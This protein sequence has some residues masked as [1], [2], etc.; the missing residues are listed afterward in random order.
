MKKQEEKPEN[1][2]RWLLTYSDL[3]TLLMIFF[4]V[5]YAGS[6]A[7]ATKYK[8]LS[9][10]FKV[11]LG[12]GKTIVGKEEGVEI[13]QPSKPIETDIKKEEGEAVKTEENK[14]QEVKSN[15]DKY[16]E[17]SS[18]KGSVSTSIEERGLVISLKDTLVFDSGKADIKPECKKQL[19]ELGAILN[20]IDNYI[21]V[22]GH[23]DNVPINTNN[24][25][26]NWQLSVIRATNVT[27]LLIKDSNIVSKRLSAVGYGE[28]RPIDTNDTEYGRG[29]NRRVDII[30]LNSKFNQVEGDKQGN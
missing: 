16:L 12:G 2:E 7:D 6:T 3:I 1:H 23:T 11:A 30:I 18:I 25:K 19:T 9:D 5:L 20:K 14:L 15:I 17:G 26:S 4:V 27:E 21:R 8:A 10:S 29:R 24:F 22:E 28:F 13:V